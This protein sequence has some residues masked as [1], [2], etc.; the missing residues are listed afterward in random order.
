MGAAVVTKCDAVV[1]VLKKIPLGALHPG[2]GRLLCM[3]V[4]FLEAVKMAL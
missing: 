3:H 1:R 4:S 2:H